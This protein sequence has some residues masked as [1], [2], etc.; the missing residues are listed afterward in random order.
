MMLSRVGDTLY[1]MSRYLERAEHTAR[2]LDLQLHLMLDQTEINPVRRW[3]HLLKSLHLPPLETGQPDAF[4][5]THWLTFDPSNEFSILSFISAARENARHV[6]E[7]ISSEMWEQINRLYF[8]VKQTSIGDIWNDQPHEFFRS[9]KEGVHL[10]Q[11]ITDSTMSNGEGWSFIQMGRFLE[12]ANMIARLVDTHYQQ[13]AAT[14]LDQTVNFNFLEWVGLLKSCTAYEAYCKV[15]TADVRPDLTAEYLI[16]NPD[17]PHTVRYSVDRLTL[18]IQAA[19]SS[20]ESKRARHVTRLAGK[21]R[22]MMDYAQMDEI[23]ADGLHNY[24]ETIQLQCTQIHN[25][26][27]SAFIVYPADEFVN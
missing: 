8:Q 20:T 16:L 22:A 27:Y 4:E 24:L 6:R 15:Y 14:A 23:L 26:I 17:F 11:G 7:Q 25:A 19:A 1:W 10:F 12:R 21:L 3:N 9:V 2:L 5:M 13:F 18:A